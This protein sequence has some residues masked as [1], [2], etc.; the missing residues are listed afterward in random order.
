M[1]SY[2]VNTILVV[3]KI[4]SYYKKSKFNKKGDLTKKLVNWLGST[5]EADSDCLSEA[6]VGCDS[7]SCGST[8]PSAKDSFHLLIVGTIPTS[9]MCSS[10]CE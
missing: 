7:E 4:S 5:Q 6:P 1:R 8:A 3:T 9:V 10:K 2:S